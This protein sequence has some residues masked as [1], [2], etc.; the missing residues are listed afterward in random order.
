[1]IGATERVKEYIDSIEI[2][3]YK[4]CQLLG[5]SNKFLDNSSNMGTDKA[6]KILRHFPDINPEW[7][8]TGDGSMLK[9]EDKRD[10]VEEKSA[11]YKKTIAGDNKIPLYNVETIDGIIDLFGNNEYQKPIDIIK[12]PKITDCDGALYISGDSM[13]P[14]LKSGDIAI[15]KKIYNP[16]SNI[17]WGEMYLVYIKNDENEY[18]F[19]RFLKQS[20]RESY[21]QLVA[22]NVNHQTIEFPL[23]S[24]MALALVKG[25]VR[26]NTQF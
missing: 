20:E 24:I 3:K 26:I 25:S 22:Q 12:I 5:F 18:F 14:V 21:I 1:M 6:C 10:L 23:S 15:Y 13:H 4:F 7:L 8:L 9:P 2:S 17:I 16:Q 19:T 11:L